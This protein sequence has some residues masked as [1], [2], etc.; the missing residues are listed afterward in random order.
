MAD[1]KTQIVITAKD[2][3]QAAIR[4]AQ[5][6]MQQLADAASKVGF[7]GFSSGI[8][9]LAGGAALTKLVTDTI[10]WA[11]ALDDLA[12]KT[13]ASVESL[14]GLAKVASISGTSIETVET[15]LIRLAKALA[16]ADEEAK[17]AG[18]ALE[19]L[20]LDPAKLRAMDSAEAL[21]AVA[22]RLGEY[23][24][25]VGKT[26][27]AQDLFGKSGAQMLPYLK[28]LSDQLD[29]TGK[30][31]S[32]QAAAAEALEKAWRR[33]TS[34]GGAVAKGLV[35]DLIPAFGYVVDVVKG[36]RIGIAQ[37]GASLAVV[38]NDI[39]TAVRIVGA[40]GRNALNPGGAKDEIGQ[41]LEERAR[42]VESANEDLQ[43]R[44]AG[45]KS[46]SEEINKI[47]AGGGKQL[48]RLDYTSRDPKAGKAGK[49]EKPLSPEDAAYGGYPGA[50]KDFSAAIMRAYNDAAAAADADVLI[51]E[52]KARR[53]QDIVGQT[54]G[55]K[56]D[57]IQK[58]IDEAN[59]LLEEKLIDPEQFA[60]FSKKKLDEIQK[61]KTG[62]VDQFAELQR[63]IEG[64]GKSSADAIVEFAMTGK[65]KFGDMV[66][67]IIKDLARM[68]VYQ[69]VTKPLFDAFGG[70]LKGILPS[71]TAKSANGNVFSGPG[72]SAYSSSVVSQPTLFPF[73]NGIGLMGEAGAEA[74]LPLKR[75]N[76]RLGVQAD[77]GGGGGGVEVNVINNASGTQARAQ[78]RADAGGKTIIDVIVDTVKGSIVQDIG[79]GGVVAG[80]LE[81]TYAVNRAAGAWR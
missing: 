77:V 6:G 14:G 23:R 11:A 15:G 57:A 54:T 80:A 39:I 10:H 58:E 74:I 20:S 37:F 53:I 31:T 70:F 61:L 66:N 7:G 34:E 45:F 5:T 1:S 8:A 9:A 44:L 52:E 28:D 26:A 19:A 42:F 32:E 67:S 2:E 35:M 50:Y 49:A 68:A 56:I 60:E 29:V 33:T 46:T 81:K 76:G 79:S 22:E 38:A 75:I 40:A 47:L 48:P 25:G 30:I 73:A 21:K 71:P 12:E 36:A 43:D 65:V 4:S 18:R 59:K 51:E 24:D 13:G 63:A 72:I 69:A 3:T 27:L 17:G 78:Q 62:A 41:I 64:W 55:F 16:G